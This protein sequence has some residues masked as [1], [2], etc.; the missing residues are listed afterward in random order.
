MTVANTSPLC[1]IN[2][3]AKAGDG[4][5]GVAAL[6][7]ASGSVKTTPAP[8]DASVFATKLEATSSNDDASGA[9]LGDFLLASLVGIG[10]GVLAGAL[11]NSGVDDHKPINPVGGAAEPGMT[12]MTALTDTT[13]HGLITSIQDLVDNLLGGTVTGPVGNLIDTLIHPSTSIGTDTLAALT[14]LLQGLLGKNGLAHGLL[15]G[16]LSSG[17]LLGGGTITESHMAADASAG[18]Q[19]V[20]LAISSHITT[21]TQQA[22]AEYPARVCNT[23]AWPS[24]AWTPR[25]H[26]LAATGN[27]T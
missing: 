3:A 12:D 27:R 25:G 9:V 20:S 23:I 22:P 18:L 6:T 14:G 15:A 8:A 26:K 1:R 19:P 10:G 24:K 4:A 11:L 17:G 13:N 7:A 5:A 16:V 2:G 21:Q